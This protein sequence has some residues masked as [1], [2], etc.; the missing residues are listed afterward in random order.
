M[1]IRKNVLKRIQQL[2]LSHKD[3]SKYALI[4]EQ[5]LRRWL[6][7]K[8]ILPYNSLVRIAILLDLEA[9]HILNI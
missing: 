7:G 9:S 6:D 5:D 8:A 2:N 1:S 3:I 4:S